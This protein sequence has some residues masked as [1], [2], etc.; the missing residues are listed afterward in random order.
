MHWNI[1]LP[2]AEWFTPASPGLDALVR[3]IEDHKLVAI[4][5]ETTGLD[6]IRDRV[7]YWSLSW[8]RGDVPGQERRVCLRADVL[9]RFAHIFRDPNRR[10]ALA[11]AKYDMSLLGN[12]G[13]N[14]AGECADVATMHALL[15]EEAP[16]GLKEMSLQILG[17]S[18]ASF[19]E[20]FGKVDKK[21][22][23]DSIGRR[24]QRAEIECLQ[25]LVEYAANDAYATL[26]L[27]Y[28][29]KEALEAKSTWSAIPTV[30][31]LWDYYLETEL[32]FT[33][34]LWDCERSGFTMDFDYLDQIQKKVDTHAD[35]AHKALNLAAGRVVSPTSHPDIG[36]L[37]Y[38]ELT[39]P[40]KKRTKG[41]STGIRKPSTAKEAIDE[42]ME[43]PLEPRQLQVL[44]ALLEYGEV[45]ALKT[46]FLPALR[47]VDQYGRLHTR[48]NQNGAATGRLSSSGPNFQNIKNPDKDPF[49]I[50]RAFTCPPGFC[51]IAADYSA[52]EM[53][54][55]AAAASEEGMLDIFRRKWDIHMGNASMV[56][57]YEY[58]DIVK[59]KKIDKQIKDG[60]LPASAMTEHYKACIDARQAV[61]TIGYG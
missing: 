52:L 40:V 49:L 51:L 45:H 4:D 18:W 6:E 48:L 47:K 44:K 53:M 58:D 25:R 56:Y 2:P 41:G 12:M 23:L 29:L 43:L 46:N 60:S 5:T 32:P 21:N 28:T 30:R 61:K 11:N 10:W 39:I 20:T 8:R 42:L 16:H 15:Y 55:L 7:L 38:E 9:H 37:I 22:P 54:V 33:K 26:Q 35:A 24:L 27:Y 59:A 17:W 50:R 57:G 1:E 31:T 13:H 36:K 19:E 3:E 14:L 34:A